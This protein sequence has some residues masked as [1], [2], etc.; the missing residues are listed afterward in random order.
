VAKPDYSDTQKKMAAMQRGATG[1]KSLT[2]GDIGKNIAG[3][4]GNLASRLKPNVKPTDYAAIG[5]GMKR[6]GTSAPNLKAGDVAAGATGR[7]PKPATK[8]QPKARKK[9]AA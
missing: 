5:R 9:K 4:A 7:K 8:P 2:I 6:V 1:G 3:A